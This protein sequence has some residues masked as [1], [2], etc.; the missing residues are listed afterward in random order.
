MKLPGVKVNRREFLA[1]ALANN[2]KSEE[3]SIILEKGPIEAGVGIEKIDR[4][5]KSLVEKRTLQSSSASFAAGLPG[6]VAMAATIPADTLQFF[7][8]AL[9]LAQE[10]A[11]LYGYK[12]MWEEEVDLN[13]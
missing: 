8:V 6:G 1:G 10:L 7:G 5:A 13:V 11:Y 2:S 9:R 3:L 12:D 4:I